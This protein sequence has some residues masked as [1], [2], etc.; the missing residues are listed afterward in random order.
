MKITL[1]AVSIALDAIY[2][3]SLRSSSD[4]LPL[5]KLQKESGVG[6]ATF[7]KLRQ[8][9]ISRN[10]LLVFGQT[11]SQYT[12]WNTCKCAMNDVLAKD[13][14]KKLHTV[15]VKKESKAK[16][17]PIKMQYDEIISYL[18]SRGWT[19]TIT[20]VKENGLIRTIEEIEL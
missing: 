12:A 3:N 6:V 7:T 20:R 2:T 16:I 14:Y 4:Q 11:R 1:Q 10:L 5:S 18:R 19:G 9:L 8:E 13:V 17:M 15:E